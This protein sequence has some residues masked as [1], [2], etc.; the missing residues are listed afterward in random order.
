MRG[1]HFQQGRSF[2]L[3]ARELDVAHLADPGSV[4]AIVEFAADQIAYVEAPGRK[5]Y[6]F[7]EWDLDFETYQF[8]GVGN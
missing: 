7:A 2:Q 8:L 1:I 4:V 3:F 6:A 5:N